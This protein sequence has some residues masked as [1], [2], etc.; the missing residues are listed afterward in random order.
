[1]AVAELPPRS[2]RADGRVPPHNLDAEESL[3]G[4]MLLSRDAIVMATEIGLSAGEFYKPAH[5]HV[6]DAITSLYSAGE[7]A[8]PVTVAEELRRANLLEAMGGPAV[9]LTLQASTPA[10]SNAGRYARIIHEHALLRR[11]ISVAG[12]IAELGYSVP[13]DVIAAVDR[14]ESMVFDVAQHRVADTMAPIKELLDASL[15]RLEMLYEKGD[16]ITGLPTGYHGLD[17]L[18]S[19]LQPS[20]LVIVGARPATGKA[21]ALDTPIPTP[22]GWTTMGEL[23]PGDQ[24][25]DEHGRPCHVVYTSPVFTDHRCYEVHFD[26]GTSIVADAGHRWFAYDYPAWKAHRA[27]AGRLAA[28]P[29]TNQRLARDQSSRQRHPRVVTTQEMV[30]EGVRAGGGSRP[31]WYLP[32]AAIDLPDADLPVDPY[33]LGCWLGDGSTAGANLTLG[34]DDA[35]HFVTEFEAAGYVLQ[36]RPGHDPLCWGTSPVPGKGQ[37][38][39]YRGDIRVL[40]RELQAVGLLRGARKHVP[41]AYLRGSLK[42]RLALL[43]GLMDTDGTIDARTGVAELCL[44]DRPLIEAAWE[45]VAS[46]GHKP[47]P[48][49]EKRIPLGDGR[50]ATAWR[51]GWTPLDC[52]FRLPRKAAIYAE[53][54]SK[55][56]N[57]RA[58]RHAVV[59][60]VEIPTVP[61]RC[62]AV[63]SPSHL[64]LASKAMIPT[65][66]T[67]FSLGMAAHAALEVRRPVLLFSL[68]MSH[69]ELTQRILSAEA[70]VDATR[71]RNGKLAESDWTKISHAIGRLAEAP[72]YIDDNP[73]ATVMEIRAKARRLKSR[74]G[75]L[76]LIVIDYLQLMT[77]RTR[78]ENRQVEVSEISRGLK[79]LARELEVPVVA[80]SQLSRQLELRA[81]KRPMLADLRESGSLEQDA[82]VVMFLYRDELYNAE[83][84]DRGT[85]EVL[86]AKHRSGPTGMDRLAF[87]DHYTRFANMARNV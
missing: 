30:D 63:D 81:D 54:T 37:W 17:E 36:H 75:D 45:L 22:T 33:V 31:N 6:F 26:D 25:F 84:P 77:G 86:V 61:M 7:P 69:L 55:R 78:A 66:N 5:G 16:S 80:L 60:I 82:D 58:T 27:R 42:Q 72:L 68:E 35:P 56:R 53:K 40:A 52:V 85:C 64:F 74:V 21:L 4:A 65:H 39:G 15:T 13:D 29:V 24:V 59:D 71:M 73:Q 79:I 43:Q 20:T 50:F 14:A 51:F 28:G 11:L 34:H 48:I 3:L 57:G 1:M 10:T 41:G 87:L 19:G 83:S 67:A 62:I 76:G 38:K 2:A 18:L 23:E 9:L 32:L 49:R 46:L 8:D 47:Q 70:R 44:A 12:E